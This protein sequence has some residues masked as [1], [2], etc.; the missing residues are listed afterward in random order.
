MSATLFSDRNKL[1]TVS[2]TFTRDHFRCWLALNEHGP[3]A[4][5][6]LD[7]FDSI[8]GGCTP[9]PKFLPNFVQV[10]TDSRP[11]APRAPHP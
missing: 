5:Q 10:I 4:Q 11:E 1:V 3:D 8:F 2:V 6:L 9:D 7:F